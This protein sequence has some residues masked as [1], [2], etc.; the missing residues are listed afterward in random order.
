MSEPPTKKQKGSAES[1]EP[2]IRFRNY[3]PTT[4]TL[5]DSIVPEPEQPSIEVAVEQ[6]QAE[7]VIADSERRAAEDTTNKD[8]DLLNLAPQ[9][10]DWDLKRDI[11]PKLEKLERRTKRA[12]D[13]LVLAKMQKT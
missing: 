12:I 8:V 13:M 9:K 6:Q 1:E 7:I 10:I 5:K 3:V 11:A 2:V 4:E